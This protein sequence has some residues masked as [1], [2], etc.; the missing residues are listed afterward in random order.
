MA[1]A[2]DTKVEHHSKLLKKIILEAGVG[3]VA[4]TP[5]WC[6]LEP[7]WAEGNSIPGAAFNQLYSRYFIQGVESK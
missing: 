3:I 7:D 4:L 5:G 1:C 6:R 2:L